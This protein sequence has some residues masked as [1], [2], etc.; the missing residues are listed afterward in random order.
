[1]IFAEN[2]HPLFGIMLCSDAGNTHPITSRRLLATRRTGVP[3][4]APIGFGG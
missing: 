4:S 1:M 2:R 3:T